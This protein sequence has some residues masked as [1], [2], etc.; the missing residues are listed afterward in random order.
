MTLR[1]EKPDILRDEDQRSRRRLGEP[2]TVEH[3]ARCQPSVGLD[4]ILGHVGEY[5]VSAAKCHDGE[6]GKE[7]T[8]LSQHMATSE[9]RGNR[10][11]RQHPHREPDRDSAEGT[12]NWHGHSRRRIGKRPATSRRNPQISPNRCA[13]HD[14]WIRQREEVNREECRRRDHP[15]GRSFETALGDPHQ[16]FHDD[17]EYGGLYTQK[18]RFS[19]WQPTEGG[20]E[21]GQR[22]HDECARNHEQQPRGQPSLGAMQLSNRHRSRAA[23]LPG[24]EA[25]CRS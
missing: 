5:R 14:Q 12:S 4:D 3:F 20:V 17:G 15:I 11:Q 18:Q 16:G 21:R 1:G 23:W 22:Q 9:D 7:P 2:E 24:R 25:A 6:L 10:K 8:E 13:Q 19:E